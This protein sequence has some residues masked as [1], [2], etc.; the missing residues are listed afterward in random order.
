MEV[1]QFGFFCHDRLLQIETNSN[2]PREG[3]RFFSKRRLNCYPIY[4][5]SELNSHV[6]TNEYKVKKK[7]A[8]RYLATRTRPPIKKVYWYKQWWAMKQ[9]ILYKELYLRKALFGKE[10]S[11]K[12]TYQNL[13]LNFYFI[14][15]LS[16]VRSILRHWYFSSNIKI[17]SIILHA[18]KMPLK[19]GGKRSSK[20]FAIPL[21]CWLRWITEVFLKRK[22]HHPWKRKEQSAIQRIMENSKAAQ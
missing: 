19:Q 11:Y 6:V 16:K 12:S 4:E 20:M 8:V 13:A 5:L 17:F 1:I 7:M 9:N 2:P 22:T 21:T 18:W 10:L 3:W 14:F 15:F